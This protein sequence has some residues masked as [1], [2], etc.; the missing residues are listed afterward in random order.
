[1]AI[2]DSQT[3]GLLDPDGRGSY[4]GWADRFAEFVAA[5]N[6]SLQYANLA[7]RGKLV[8]EIHTEQVAAAL[9]LKP[10]LVTVMGGLNDVLRPTFELTQVL[11][12][13][14]VM[15]AAFEGA[16]VLTNTFPDIASVAPLFRRLGPRVEMLNAGI[17]QV[18]QERGAL[19][20]DFA[21]RAVGADPRMWSPDRIH[22]NPVGHSLIASAFADTLGLTGH[23]EW[24][25]P[26][27]A[28]VRPGRA[29]RAGTEARWVGGTVLPWVV[30]RVRGR[31][32]GDGITAKRPR[33]VPVASLFHIVT[34]D[35][36]VAAVAAGEY[37]PPSLADEGFVHF[38][39]AHQ[40]SSTANLLYRDEPE[41][42]V[43]EID[44]SAVGA[45]VLVEDTHDSGI[46]FPHVY[47]PV[48]VA[49]AVAV[50]PLGRGPDG[51][52]NFTRGRVAAAASP[53]H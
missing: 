37:R 36:W 34:P 47:G 32:S 38:S 26:L 50:H 7:I 23:A 2:G 46:D 14:D 35:A 4:R 25:R 21:A 22:A 41:L 51:D 44:P 6:P 10:D 13:L 24:T 43:V 1:V 48:P 29:A 18:A 52:W 9:E 15:L 3:E 53:G 5:S 30:R 33:L 28:G 27:P 12:H 39:F 8:G 16:T 45:D 49:A 17:R 40:V 11:G 42:L 31:S 20:V 19:V